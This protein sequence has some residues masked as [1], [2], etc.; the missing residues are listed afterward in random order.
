MNKFVSD[1]RICVFRFSLFKMASSCRAHAVDNKELNFF[2]S[3]KEE[4]EGFDLDEMPLRF[5]AR[6][7]L[8]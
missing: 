8:D 2:A 5:F 7:D 4:F 6:G 1:L 3:D